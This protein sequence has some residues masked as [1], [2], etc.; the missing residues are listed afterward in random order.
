MPAQAPTSGHILLIHTFPDE[1][2]KH[3]ETNF[4]TVLNYYINYNNKKKSNKQS[5]TEVSI[6]NF[7]KLTIIIILLLLREDIWGEIK[8][9]L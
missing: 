4:S 5:L 6:T 2:D 3:K 1:S 8:F 9:S 7:L